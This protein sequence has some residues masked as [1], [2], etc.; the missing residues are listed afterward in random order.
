MKNQVS[1]DSQEMKDFLSHIINNNR[2]IQAKGMTP[3]AT[4]IIGE[5]GL[6]KTTV[7]LDVAKE[8]GLHFVKLNLAQIEELGDLV[9]FP[10]RQFELCKELEQKPKEPQQTYKIVDKKLPNGAIVKVKE[11][12]TE[13]V[14]HSLPE[15]TTDCLWVDET[16]VTQYTKQGYSFTNRKRMTY[17]PPEWISGKEGGGILILDDWNRKIN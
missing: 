14:Q 4:E 11:L 17:A 13:P 15:L 8:H 5:S 6:G 3:V 9:G 10:V 7:A 2:F 16:A 12:I 1:L